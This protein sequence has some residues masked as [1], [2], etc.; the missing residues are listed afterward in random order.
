MKLTLLYPLILVAVCSC[1]SDPALKNA[2]S[3]EDY[4]KLASGPPLKAT[5]LKVRCKLVEADKTVSFGGQGFVLKPGQPLDFKV[6]RDFR[7]PTAFHLPEAGKKVGEGEFPVTP[8]TPT[9][10]EQREVG[11]VLKLTVETRGPFVEIAGTLTETRFDGFGRAGGEAF[12]ILSNGEGIVL[13]ENRVP[14]PQ[15]TT[16][17]SMIRVCGLPGR[18][19]HVTLPGKSRELLITCEPIR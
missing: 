4:K 11:C 14:L 19:H 10:F 7:Y 18:E 17:E 3:L 5:S 16:T 12:S 13:T 9:K 8:S 1:Q 15:F 6:I 2:V